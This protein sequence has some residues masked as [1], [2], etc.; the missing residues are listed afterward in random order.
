MATTSLIRESLNLPQTV[1]LFFWPNGNLN[2]FFGWEGSFNPFIENSSLWSSGNS[3][4]M[5]CRH[6]IKNHIIY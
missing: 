1:G 5:N 6:P 4:W 3:S 2:E